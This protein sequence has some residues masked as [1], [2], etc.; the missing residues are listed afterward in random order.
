M[1]RKK[2]Q[3]TLDVS[4]FLRIRKW[5]LLAL[6]AIAITIIVAQI[7]IQQHLNSQLNDSRVINVAGRQ[8]AY[9][10]KLVK[11]ALLLQ[12]GN[13]DKNKHSELL[14]RLENTLFIWKTS[15]EGLQN[16]NDSIGLPKED[17][18]SILKHFEELSPHHNAMVNAVRT[19]L[20]QGDSGSHQQQ[21]DILL[22]NEAPFLEKMDA[23]VNEYDAIS[24]ERLQRLKLKEYLL[25]AFSLLILILEVLFIFR[26]LSIQIK[27][28]IQKLVKSR[29]QS[30]QDA[31]EI[32]KIFQEKEKSLQELKELNF[33]IDNAALF[34][35]ARN[36]G[37]VVFIS[38]KFLTLLETSNIP[39]NTHLSE[40]LTTDEGQRQYL[41][42][43]LTKP[44]KSIRTEEIEI[45]TKAGNKLWLDMSI[46]PMH[47][48]SLK[49]SVLLLCSD[50]TERKNNQEK[51]EQLTLQNYED[52][53]RQKQIQASL[54]VEG[55]E[56]ER[57]RIAKDIHDGIGQMLT[58][59]RFNIES[60]N[61]DQKERTK[62]KIAYLK[63]LTSDLIKGVRTATFNLTPPE[64]GDHGIFPALQKMTS[65]LSKLTGKNILFENKAE[66]NIRFDSL[67]ETNIYRV[68][69]EAVNNAIKYADANYILVSINHT[70]NLLSVVIDDD[71]KGFDPTVLE[72]PPKN[73]SEGG[74]GVFF[75]KER[76][77]YINGR[78]FINSSPG[79]GTRVTIN[80][81]LNETK[82]PKK[83]TYED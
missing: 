41:G 83:E 38:K 7:L 66:Q 69:Q 40:I 70:D 14:E 81:N 31:Q 53:M 23:I 77:S 57:K 56:E 28:T 10:Q 26:P 67:A 71:G 3:Q 62:E 36:D 1:K 39:P 43:I 9:S 32:K 63:E 52:R 6:S 20:K 65:E 68:T 50:I 58:A 59:L 76:I 11:E 73:N 46:V 82:K 44:R 24:K 29:L 17:N 13:L 51:V 60:I 80:Y 47:Q 19:I 2:Q 34:A 64:L 33:V 79:E 18:P 48:T 27:E 49:Q 5:Y 35:S 12:S 75:M 25:L 4:T 30:E 37:T 8:R 42:E 72:R 55:Q 74:M 78:L 54:I 16:G 21:M 22:A 15:H 45:K 61:L